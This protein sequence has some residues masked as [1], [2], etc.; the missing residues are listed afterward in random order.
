MRILGKRLIAKGKERRAKRR[1]ATND[2][3]HA[4]ENETSLP[5]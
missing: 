2:K 1:E 4:A 3:C 5:I